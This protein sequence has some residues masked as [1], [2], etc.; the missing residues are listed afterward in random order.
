M[1]GFSYLTA[2]INILNTWLNENRKSG[3][4]SPHSFKKIIYFTIYSTFNFAKNLCKV[5]FLTGCFQLLSAMNKAALN[6]HMQVVVKIRFQFLCKYQRSA[7]AGC[8]GKTRFD[9][10]KYYQTV[11]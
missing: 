6:I 3:H 8:Y 2:L 4:F 7:N 9:F 5:E 10:I 1:I 11:F